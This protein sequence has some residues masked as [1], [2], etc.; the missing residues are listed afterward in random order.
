MVS[1]QGLEVKRWQ[2]LNDFYDKTVKLYDRQLGV[3]RLIVLLM[4]LLTVANA[5]NMAVYERTGELGTMRA[6][7]NRSQSLF[8]LLMMEGLIL[9]LIGS[10]AGV[11]LG[12]A[13]AKVISLLGIPMP[14][15]PNAN[16]GYTAR[17]RVDP[18]GIASAFFVGL[19]ATAA[20]SYLPALRALR[21]S[22][23]DALRENI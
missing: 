13:L 23:V 9:G 6:L 22:V 19:I 1:G 15:P 20:A 11:A 14:P 3:L 17:I 18:S 5:I 21:V 12:I 4:V 2:S 16:L 10:A 7:G 8:F